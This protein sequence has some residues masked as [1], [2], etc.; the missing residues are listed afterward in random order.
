MKNDF[1]LPQ[2]PSLKP[3]LS[4]QEIE[5]KVSQIGERIALDYLGKEPIL[6]CVLRGGVYFFSDLTRAIPFPV[7]VDFLQA[8]SYSGKG[9]S[10]KVELLKDLD[11]D[12]TDRHV[13]LL[14][15]IVDT[16]L[17]LKF[18]IR[19][20]LSR[21]PMTLEV[22]SLLC[23]EGMENVEYPVKYVGWHIGNEFV[24]GYGLDFDGRFRNLPDIYVFED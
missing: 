23:K 9:S 16:G 20:I 24:V 6:V 15:D 7:E 17:T 4:R 19:H 1:T 5:S 3:F 13:L 22:V 11:S 2:N 12:I 18:L 10:G 14:E 8:R 21:N